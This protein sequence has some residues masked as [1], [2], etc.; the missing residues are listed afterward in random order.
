MSHLHSGK[1][2][3]MTITKTDG[4]QDFDFAIGRWRV[5]NRKLAN[6]LDLT[7]T[8]W[9]EFD[10]ICE[11]HP[12]LDGLGNF[13]TFVPIGLPED[14]HYEGATL[15]MF[16]PSTGLWRM[17]WVSSRTTDRVDEPVAGR[18]TDGH[19]QFFCDD[20]I[21]GTPVKVRYDWFD[22]E[23]GCTRWEQAFSRDGGATWATNWV[24]TSAREDAP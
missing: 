19:G 14:K 4:R 16:D 18:F 17:W 7:C 8:D 3:P 20:V 23:P 24:M 15:R 9:I 12:I 2:Q 1:A 21:S 13:D 22:V 6:V 10:A 5:H 11:V